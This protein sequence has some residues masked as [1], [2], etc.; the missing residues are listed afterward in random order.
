MYQL[1]Y[2][3]WKEWADVNT[4]AFFDKAYIFCRHTTRPDNLHQQGL[5]GVPGQQ[6]LVPPSSGATNREPATV[7]S[8]LNQQ[9]VPAVF[10]SGYGLSV[11]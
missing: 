8:G 1:M 10:I 7:L 9:K 5:L 6:W 11:S 2:Q 4:W 3:M